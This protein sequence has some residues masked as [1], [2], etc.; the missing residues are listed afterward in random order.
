MTCSYSKG[1]AKVFFSQDSLKKCVGTL[2]K[3]KKFLQK[4][5]EAVQKGVITFFKWNC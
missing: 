5:I 3:I 2:N 4:T 1:V